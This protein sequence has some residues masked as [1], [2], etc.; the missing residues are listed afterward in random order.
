MRQAA[1]VD[2]NQKEIV[3]ALRKVATV[4]VIGLP[5]DLAVGFRGKTYLLEVKTGRKKKLTKLQES[6]FSTWR[7]HVAR[8]ETV[9]EAFSAIGADL[10]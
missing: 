7:G 1:R 2:A 8:V 4:Y 9:E 3:A 6:F 10:G 5:V